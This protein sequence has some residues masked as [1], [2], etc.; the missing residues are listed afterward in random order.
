LIDIIPR[1][2][3]ARGAVEE[4]VHRRFADCYQADIHSFMP[5]LLRIRED[6]S[7]ALQAVAGLR[8]AES[9]QGRQRLF[10]EHYLDCPVEEAITAAGG[11]RVLRREIVEIGNL[12]ESD[13]GGGRQAIIALTGFLAGYGFRWVVFT[14]ISRLANAFPRLGME[15]LELA[16]ADPGSLP[17]EERRAWGSYYD[18]SPRVLCGRISDGF[19][20]LDSLQTPLSGELRSSL[21][22][23]YHIGR[24][25]HRRGLSLV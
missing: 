16:V 7:G 6:G 9:E 21:L 14:A 5:C 19:S 12:A 25:W 23:G 1:D 4:F 13:A 20:T 3:H 15:P 22:V 18:N 17:P 8:P 2:H 10:V 11:D 24:W